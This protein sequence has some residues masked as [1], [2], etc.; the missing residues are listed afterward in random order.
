VSD[1]AVEIPVEVDLEH[2]RRMISR[3][4]RRLGLNTLEAKGRQIEHTHERVD[5]SDGTLLA[6]VLVDRLW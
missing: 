5:H 4:T 3:P 2:R 6:D 1:D